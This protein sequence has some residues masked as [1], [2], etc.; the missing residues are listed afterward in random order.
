M[1]PA[2]PVPILEGKRIRL[3]APQNADE[4][5]LYQWYND[6]ETVAPFD[7]FDIDT[8][9]EFRAEVRRASSDPA[10]LAPRFVVERREDSRVLGFVGHYRAHPVLELVDVW[11]VLGDPGERG[12][13]YGSEAV[14]L[15]VDYLFHDLALVRVG[16]TTDVENVASVKLLEHLG[17]QRE[18]ILRAALR[19]HGKWHDVAVYGVSRATWADR[20]RSE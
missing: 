5:V 17:F 2:R 20:A 7:R 16:A 3:R 13:G 4:S 9:D 18:G 6:P 12:K 11:Y 15:L 1:A 14:G 8:L 19:H 10:S